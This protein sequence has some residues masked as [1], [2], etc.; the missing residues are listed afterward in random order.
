MDT[1]VNSTDIPATLKPLHAILKAAHFAAQKH[2]EQRRKGAAAE[3]FVNQL[4]EVAELVSGALAE[5]DPNA[6]DD[7]VDRWVVEEVGEPEAGLRSTFRLLYL[8]PGPFH[9]ED[10]AC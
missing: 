6:P 1:P 3:P 9:V 4:I 2:A 8:L 7:P 5:L 10:H